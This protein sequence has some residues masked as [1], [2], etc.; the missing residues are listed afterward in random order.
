MKKLSLILALV[1]V[2]LTFA[3]CGASYEAPLKNYFSAIQNENPEKMYKATFDPFYAEYILDQRDLDDDETDELVDECK[4]MVKE[5]YDSLE[6]KYGKN[7]KIT[8]KV[9]NVRKFKKADVTYL[10]QYLEDEYDYDAKKVKDVVVLTVKSR[11]I[12]DED[13]EAETSDVV[14]IKVSGKWYY[15]QIFSSLSSVKEA[16]REAKWD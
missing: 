7:I 11:V 13:N 1:L 10:G 8:Y 12:G 4:D 16:I 2:M 9:E 3:S 5:T 14:L 6:D 15:S